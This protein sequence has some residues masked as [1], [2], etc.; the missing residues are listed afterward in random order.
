M[1]EFPSPAAM[2]RRQY[3]ANPGSMAELSEVDTDAATQAV[4]SEISVLL[5]QVDTIRESAG[6]SFDPAALERLTAL[7]EQAHESLTAALDAV[8]R[9]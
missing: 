9:R 3:E 7:L 6:D 8:D 1:S 2:P 4:H 5:E